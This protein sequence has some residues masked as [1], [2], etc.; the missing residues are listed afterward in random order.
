MDYQG[1][2]GRSTWEQGL[3]Y[4]EEVIS[5]TGR[6][7]LEYLVEGVGVLG[8]GSWSTW[9]KGG[10]RNWEREGRWELEYLKG[11]YQHIGYREKQKPHPD[12]RP[13][14]K[15]NPTRGRVSTRTNSKRLR[16][17]LVG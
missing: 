17:F 5:S 1:R 2:E 15:P 13:Y 4:P 3:E 7:E 16:R 12:P 10:P 6:G 14:P 9:E 8:R 11:E